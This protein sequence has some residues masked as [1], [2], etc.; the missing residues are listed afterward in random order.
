MRILRANSLVWLGITT[1]TLCLAAASVVAPGAVGGRCSSSPCSY[2]DAQHQEHPG[3]CGSK[4][5]DNKNCYCFDN[6]DKKL[7]NL[8]PACSVTKKK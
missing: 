5:G 4:K 3:T 2:Y 8:Q 1:A 6:E 7:S